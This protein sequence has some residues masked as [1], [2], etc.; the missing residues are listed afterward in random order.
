MKTKL[1]VASML[2]LLSGN[3]LADELVVN[4]IT[5]AQ[6]GQAVLDIQMNN[7]TELTAFQFDVKMAEGISVAKNEKG[8]MVYSMGDRFQDDDEEFTLSLSNPETNLYRFLGYHTV[9]CPIS[10]NKGT[11]AT[12]T[13]EASSELT[14]GTTYY[15]T[16]TNIVFTE[17]SGLKHYPDDVTFA[18]TIDG[19][20]DGRIHFDET[21]SNLPR[22]TAGDK[23][24]VTMKRTIKGGVWNT[25]VLPFTLT[26]AKAEAAFGTDV[27]LSEFS[28]FE[29]EYADED[30]VSPDAIVINFTSYTMSAR[31]GITGGKPFLIKTSKDV[32]EFE[33]D[34]VTLTDVAT[35]V[36]KAD[37]Y[38][39]A[40]KFTGSLV[41][42]VVPADGLFISDNKFWYSTGKTNIKAFRGWFELGAVLGK[43]TDFGAKVRFVIDGAPTSIEGIES[44][45]VDGDVYTLQGIYVGRDVDKNRLPKG[46]YIIDG[47][48]T[49]VK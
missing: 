24:D 18:V 34:D 8:K 19:V 23:G 38:D 47:K 27:Q 13:L 16:I 2:A 44:T 1:V 4:D 22:Y 46:I 32:T 37:E 31:K 45:N 41:K 9:T 12:A 43:D 3:V 33:A 17:T 7:E 26:K 49:F 5:I 29:V 36:E 6:G 20:D 42:T 40:G 21:S 25:I 28:G 11:I 30:D 10:G 14:V 48:K 39:T 15:C 35:S